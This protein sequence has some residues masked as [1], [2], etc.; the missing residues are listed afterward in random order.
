MTGGI[1][2]SGLG[3]G[4][5]LGSDARQRAPRAAREPEARFVFEPARE[6]K[7]WGGQGFV[8]DDGHHTSPRQILELELDVRMPAHAEPCRAQALLTS[9]P[10]LWKPPLA[11]VAVLEG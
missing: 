4:A 5:E 11:G 10:H 7:L 2:A 6:G 8:G 9:G 1:D 3:L